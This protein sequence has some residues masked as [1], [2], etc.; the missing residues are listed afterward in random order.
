[1]TFSEWHPGYA[2]KVHEEARQ[3]IP[4]TKRGPYF[5]MCSAPVQR[6]PEGKY[7]FIGQ[8]GRALAY[9]STW[10]EHLMSQQVSMFWDIWII[11]QLSQQ[12]RYWE[13]KT[14]M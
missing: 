7:E 8:G 13:K 14:G 3:I 4:G 1:L 11:N 6:E 9:R 2:K 12:R 5:S 10:A